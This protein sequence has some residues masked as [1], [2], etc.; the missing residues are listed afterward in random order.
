MPGK[1]H[2][3]QYGGHFW[4]TFS[5]YA[6]RKPMVAPHLDNIMALPIWKSTPTENYFE[7]CDNPPPPPHL[8]KYVSALRSIFGLRKKSNLLSC[9]ARILEAGTE[10]QMT[11]VGQ[12]NI[13]RKLQDALKE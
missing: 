5:L 4:Q 7:R 11:L 6:T 13:E 12:K 9:F 2:F 8:V 10:S 3:R 1:C